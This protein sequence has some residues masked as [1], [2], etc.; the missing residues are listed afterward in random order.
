MLSRKMIFIF[1]VNKCKYIEA[2]KFLQQ[3]K[4]KSRLLTDY[5]K[6]LNKGKVNWLK[7]IVLFIIIIKTK[8]KVH[9]PT[10]QL[11]AS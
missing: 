6:T 4:G 11:Q 10:R 9:P 7:I 5:T 2:S 8:L 1:M 3:D